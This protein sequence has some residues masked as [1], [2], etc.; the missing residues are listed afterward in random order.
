VRWIW[1]LVA[2]LGIGTGIIFFNA[3]QLDSPPGLTTP[4]GPAPEELSPPDEP[5]KETVP[6][7][8]TGRSNQKG[9]VL[10]FGT[11]ERDG[12]RPEPRDL[13]E[14]PTL[15]AGIREVLDALI[16]GSR[17]GLIQ[18]IPRSTRVL[19][20]FLDD[21]G[22]AYV[23]FSKELSTNQPGGI[24]TEASTVA[25]IVQTLTANFEAVSKV[26]FLVEGK[27]LETLAGHVDVRNPLSRFDTR[28][29][30]LADD[31]P[32]PPADNP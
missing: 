21:Q 32:D 14:S 18:T 10:Y 17:T 31:S 8:Q 4:A 13:S 1:V 6:E 11:P 23:D 7:Y 2:I 16:Q 28:S 27:I 26:A 15:R 5:P 20:I 19:E 29:F 30:L 3:E 22:T 25:S 9:F 24:W 12:L